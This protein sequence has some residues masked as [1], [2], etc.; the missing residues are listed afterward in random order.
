[1]LLLECTVDGASSKIPKLVANV[2]NSIPNG[3]TDG[4]ALPHPHHDRRSCS[5]FGLIPPSGLGEDSVKDGRRWTK[6]L[7]SHTLI[8]RG[9]DL[10]SSI[11]FA[12]KFK[13]R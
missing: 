1:M 3:R 12:W 5:K 13:R 4:L 6:I 7:L 11:E 2:A 8:T 10:V 9:S